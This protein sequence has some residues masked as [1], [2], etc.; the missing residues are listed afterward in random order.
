MSQRASAGEFLMFLA[1][2]ATQGKML[3]KFITFEGI[4]GCGKTTQIRILNDFLKLR[5]YM[6]LLTRE[7]G[8]TAIGEKIRQVLLNADFKEMKSMTELLLYAAAR[9][10]HVHQI[11]LPAIQEGK[12]VLCD[13][14][15]DATT[16][17]QGGARGIDKNFLKNIHQVATNGLKPDLTILLDCPVEIGLQRIRERESEIP[18]QTNLDRFEKEK[19][20]FHEK[21]REAYL[22]IAKEEPGRVKIISA[23]DDIQTIHD[24][25]TQEVMRVIA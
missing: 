21:V 20:D 15:A 6:T 18:G 9:C 4:E 13:R 8:G 1:F 10:Q 2:S 3:G 7:P 5:G 16:A 14:Y 25:I 23:L 22:R 11:I 24:K 12:I 19:I 17:Y